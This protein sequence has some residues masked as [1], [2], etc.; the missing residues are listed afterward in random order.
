MV[1][2]SPQDSIIAIGKVKEAMAHLS[3]NYSL[4]ASQVYEFFVIDKDGHNKGY[5]TSSGELHWWPVEG[6]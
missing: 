2:K 6:E 5:I 4:V 3:G 1:P